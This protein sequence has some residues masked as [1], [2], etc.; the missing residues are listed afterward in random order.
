M[1]NDRPRPTTPTW[2]KLL[3]AA[4]RLFLGAVTLARLWFDG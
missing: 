1:M 3:S 4:S 2:V